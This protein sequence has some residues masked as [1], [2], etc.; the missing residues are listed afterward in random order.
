MS[1]KYR[2]EIKSALELATDEND[3]VDVARAYEVVS[4]VIDEIERRVGVIEDAMNLEGG[5]YPD[6]NTV[7]ESL[8]DLGNDLY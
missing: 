3:M 7:F 8:R 6:L 2:T 4:D 1:G 5:V